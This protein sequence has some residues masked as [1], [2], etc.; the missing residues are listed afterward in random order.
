MKLVKKLLAITL[1]V[2][3]LIGA[4]LCVDVAATGDPADTSFKLIQAMMIPEHWEDTTLDRDTQVALY[5]TGHLR[6]VNTD[7]IKAFIGIVN[8][9]NWG[10]DSSI[11]HYTYNGND[12]FDRLSFSGTLSESS[13][14]AL[15]GETNA[16]GMENT[17]NWIFT[18]DPTST[19]N[20]SKEA[21]I[22]PKYQH[23]VEGDAVDTIPEMFALAKAAG[24][25]LAVVI[26]DAGSTG[27]TMGNIIAR[28]VQGGDPNVP[29]VSDT[30]TANKNN[31][32]NNGTYA[33]AHAIVYDET[34]AA[35]MTGAT[36]DNLTKTLTVNFSEP[37]TVRKGVLSG[38]MV[39]NSNNELMASKDGAF[40]VNG[41]AGY[42]AMFNSTAYPITIESGAAS[43]SIVLNDA[44]YNRIIN[45]QTMVD[46]HN[47]T[48]PEDPLRVLFYIG[49]ESTGTDTTH[50]WR[51]EAKSNYYMDSLYTAD[52]RPFM[53]NYKKHTSAGLNDF[54]ATEIEQI[55]L[56]GEESIIA[57][58]TT[59]SFMNADT[60]RELSVGDTTEFK[61]VSAGKEDV[62]YLKSGEQYL[63]LTGD[64]AV[65]S[66]EAVSYSILN[67]ANDRYQILIGT[68]AVADTD[69]GQDDKVTLG[70]VSVTDQTINSGWYVTASGEEKPLRILPIGDSITD[71]DANP[72]NTS[73]KLGWRDD[74][75]TL[76]DTKLDRY[77]F[78]GS[79]VTQTTTLSETVLARHEGHSGAT[80][81]DLYAAGLT[82]N[83]RPVL[84]NYAPTAA[85]K[86]TPDV[87][88]LMAGVN[89][90][91]VYYNDGEHTSEDMQALKAAYKGLV[92]VFADADTVFCSTLTPTTE[93]HTFYHTNAQAVKT[94]NETWDFASWVDEWKAEGLPVVLNDN[95]SAL[96]GQEGTAIS[97]D[98]LH[99]NDVG[100]ALIAQQ[101]A[102]SITGRYMADG[103][104]KIAMVDGQ[105]YSTL[106]EALAN[107]TDD[108]TIVLYDDVTV[109]ETISVPDGVTLDLNGKTLTAPSVMVSGVIKDS[110][111][112]EGLVAVEKGSLMYNEG[113]ADSGVMPLFETEKGYR[114]FAVSV[115]Q[116]NHRS[117]ATK[118]KYGV[119]IVLGGDTFN[120]KAYNLL[121]DEANADVTLTFNLNLNGDTPITYTVRRA[122]MIAYAE[123]LLANSDRVGNIVVV[124]SVY[125]I[126]EMSAGMTLD[127]APVLTSGTV[128]KALGGNQ[129]YT[130]SVT[131]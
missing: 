44:A 74:L 126:E 109:D 129:T 59:Y 93:A 70:L 56:G 68:S 86:Y 49:E 27:D 8:A 42:G 60:G 16:Y 105:N 127:C 17:N 62:W 118:V 124:L 38:L 20:M 48:Y 66:D 120:E 77:V 63:N 85:A 104:R 69:G 9:G 102:A 92:E 61:A 123:R 58:G 116:K 87:V 26:V 121:A 30:K 128:A 4:P 130:H 115:N 14:V 88:L 75:A 39:F 7:Y 50:P 52:L 67:M 89:D 53:A 2:C 103:T 36:L 57:E 106:E 40:A 72:D 23:L 110:T 6:T 113:A 21:N 13:D 25:R 65:L 32:N 55:V 1:A 117:S 100:N 96:A 81:T 73:H 33:G 71:G 90:T 131:E 122:T 47:A 24:K 35:R 28:T 91:A 98:G 29:L 119:A 43:G 83:Q 51:G 12:V 107:A 79:Q 45:W 15:A 111:Q 22:A 112:G 31:G 125:G 34:T 3:M 41:T 99:P 108:D 5:F 18:M 97:S 101:Y 78:V 114:L 82:S 84:M 10:Y 76:L 37:M 80:I 19:N 11:R 95:Y 64:G 94:F 46:T 54:M